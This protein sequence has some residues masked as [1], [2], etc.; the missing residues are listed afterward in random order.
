[1]EADLDCRF[2]GSQRGEHRRGD[3][4]AVSLH[5]WYASFQHFTC[6]A[7]VAISRADSQTVRVNII[8][9]IVVVEYIEE[10]VDERECCTHFPQVDFGGLKY[11]SVKM[12]LFS[13]ICKCHLEARVK[14]LRFDAQ[15][16]DPNEFSRSPL[17]ASDCRL[18]LEHE[19][20]KFQHRRLGHFDRIEKWVLPHIILDHEIAGF[21]EQIFGHILDHKL[22]VFMTLWIL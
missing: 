1:M 5:E 10:A 11:A 14:A 17:E 16:I 15:G 22:F 9:D 19:P 7:P 4:Q 21:L 2:L 8:I 18:L 13:I 6:D 20:V 3:A 12:N